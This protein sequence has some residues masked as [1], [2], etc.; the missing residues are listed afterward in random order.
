MLIHQKRDPQWE[1]SFLFTDKIPFK[2]LKA[3][4]GFVLKKQFQGMCLIFK[5]SASGPLALLFLIGTLQKHLYLRKYRIFPYSFLY[6]A[7]KENNLELRSV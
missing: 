6:T 5:V 1:W 7:A 4:N 2:N 3:S